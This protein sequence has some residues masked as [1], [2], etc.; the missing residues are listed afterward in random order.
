MSVQINDMLNKLVIQ[1]DPETKLIRI[2]FM[3]EDR[4]IILNRHMWAVFKGDQVIGENWDL[5][6]LTPNL[7]NYER[8]TDIAMLTK[9]KNRCLKDKL[10]DKFINLLLVLCHYSF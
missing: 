10:D 7:D 8:L 3:Q 6:S 9:I 5:D 2:N 1:K 4:G